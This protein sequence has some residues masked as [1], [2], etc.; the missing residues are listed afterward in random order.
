M[1]TVTW[2]NVLDELEASVI[3]GEQTL[4]TGATLTDLAPWD[5]PTGLGPIPPEL[6]GRARDLAERQRRVLSELP[7]AMVRVRRQLDLTR[8]IGSATAPRRPSVYIDQRA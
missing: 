2:A 5:R 4:L 7:G 3:V 6:I 1:R 8:K